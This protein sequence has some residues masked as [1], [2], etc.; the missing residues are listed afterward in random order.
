MCGLRS[1]TVRPILSGDEHG[2]DKFKMERFLHDGRHSIAS[3]FAPITYPALP[4]LLVSSLRACGLYRMASLFSLLLFDRNV[5]SAW[6]FG[7]IRLL[8]GVVA[9]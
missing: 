2:A 8:S 7:S 1:F 5:H 3:V 9:V 6:L 4:V